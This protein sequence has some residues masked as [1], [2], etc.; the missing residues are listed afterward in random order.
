M[1]EVEAGVLHNPTVDYWRIGG[2]YR[3]DETDEGGGIHGCHLGSDKLVKNRNG[4]VA[5]CH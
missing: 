5:R 3:W 4:K 2:S 1:A